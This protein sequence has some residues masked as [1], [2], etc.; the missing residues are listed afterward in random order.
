LAILGDATLIGLFLFFVK[1][2][3]V[4]K[5]CTSVT[6]SHVVVAGIIMLTFANINIALYMYQGTFTGGEISLRFAPSF[7]N[8]VLYERKIKFRSETRMT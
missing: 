2:P 3:K 1:P 8:V 4:A 5:A 6:L 7:K